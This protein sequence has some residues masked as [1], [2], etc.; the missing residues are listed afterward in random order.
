MCVSCSY[1][2]D[3]GNC[4]LSGIFCH[5]LRFCLNELLGH[6]HTGGRETTIGLGQAFIFVVLGK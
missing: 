6:N 4:V 2:V 3:F 1:V 5:H